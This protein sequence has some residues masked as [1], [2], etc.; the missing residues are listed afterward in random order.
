M[1]Y[2]NLLPPELQV[3]TTASEAKIR[4]FLKIL[5]RYLVF[6]AL[7]IVIV[8]CGVL[9]VRYGYRKRKN[10]VTVKQK[11]SSPVTQKN[12]ATELPSKSVVMRQQEP[13]LKP[14][15]KASPA[16]VPPKPYVNESDIAKTISYTL[17]LGSFNTE[18]EA[19]AQIQKMRKQKLAPYQKIK[20]ITK[21]I[22][23]LRID[24]FSAMEETMELIRQLETYGFETFI[25]INPG[26][27][28][29]VGVKGFPDKVK[30][31]E[32]AKRLLALGYT[33]EVGQER[34]PTDVYQVNLGHYKYREARLMQA[35]LE[36]QGYRVISIMRE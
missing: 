21:N 35:E 32:L 20:Q 5:F 8:Y 4:A 29:V 2:I 34:L 12:R 9:L 26:E 13:P 14:D 23:V 25:K 27:A 18:D 10:E 11:A 16:I 7:A 30:T 33:S 31:E 17:C 1:K 24:R 15:K 6:P 36:Y 19:A 22:N 3:I 28:Y